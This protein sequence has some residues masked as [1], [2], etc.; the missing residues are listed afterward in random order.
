MKCTWSMIST[1]PW[2]SFATSRLIYIA[3]KADLKARKQCHL[4]SQY[5][6]CRN[7]CDRCKAIQPFSSVPHPMTYKNMSLDAPYSRTCINH[8]DYIREA[9]EISPWQA[10]PGWSFET[11]PYDF[12]H[13]VYLGIAKN[14]YLHAWRFWSFGVT[15]R[16]VKVMN[17]SSKGPA[18]R[19]RMIAKEKSSL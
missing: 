12:M 18:L 13:L 16:K 1:Y 19:W 8:S 11:L 17:N 4:L 5:Y 10:V 6:L 7:L 14:T 2:C 3:F 9:Q 15:M